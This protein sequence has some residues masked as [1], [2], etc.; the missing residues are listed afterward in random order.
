MDHL[1]A[2]LR[3]ENMAKIRSKNTS[4]EVS[5]RKFLSSQGLRFRL[6]DQRLPGSPDVVFIKKKFAIFIN[7][8][9]W[10]QHK[11]CKRSTIPKSNQDY[12][13]PK[14]ERNIKK[15]ENNILKL[16]KSSWNTLTVWECEVK[17]GKAYNKIKEKL[18]N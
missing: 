5:V 1:A 6:H 15:F 14:L 13:I 8:C 4:P 18:G 2:N 9:F 12:W 11:G 17:N 3:S 7:G 16:K 10:H